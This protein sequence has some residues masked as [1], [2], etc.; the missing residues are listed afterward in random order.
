V[1]D[2]YAAGL[3]D[4]E[5]YIGI[6]EAGGSMQIRLKVA[7]TDKGLPSLRA[8]QRTFGGL[9][10][11]D[12]DATETTRAAHVWR[13]NG[14]KAA[15]LLNRLYPMLLTKAQ[16]ARIA[17]EF[18]DMLNHCDRRPNGTSLWTEETH[19]Q[20]HIFRARIQEANR[21]GPDPAPPMLLPH[22]RP[23]AVYRYGE[24]WELDED[25]FGPVEFRGRWPT[26]GLMVGGRIY[27]LSSPLQ[28]A[29]TPTA[30]APTA[31]E[32]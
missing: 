30:P 18:Q 31:T 14:Q 16:P 12:R 21:T 9:L 4:G 20:A 23:L 1:D 8:M 13:L 24:W 7:M 27:P 29:A 26:S 19:R 17:L 2:S 5:G 6:Q 10:R 3:I 25:L 11:P 15:D 28:R 22:R 32:D